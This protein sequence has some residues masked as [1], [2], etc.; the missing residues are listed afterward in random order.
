MTL[1]THLRATRQLLYRLAEGRGH[2]TPLAHRL[3]LHEAAA[4]ALCWVRQVPASRGGRGYTLA[5]DDSCPGMLLPHSVRSALDGTLL[6]VQAVRGLRYA[7]AHSTWVRAENNTHK[8]LNGTLGAVLRPDSQPGRRFALTAGHVCGAAPS[9]ASGDEVR[10]SFAAGGAPD[11]MGR[12]LDWQPNFT[13]LPLECTLDAGLAEVSAE[14]LQPLMAR[15]D[16]WPTGDSMAFPEDRLSLRSQG[17]V[18]TGGDAALLGAPLCLNGDTSRSYFLRDALVW[19]TR[20]PSKAGDSGAPVWNSSDELVG[21]HA[22]GQLNDDPLS[23]IA[24]PIT[25]ILRWAGASLVRRS[26]L[27]QPALLAT[28]P[29]APAARRNESDILARTLYGEAIGEGPDGMAAVAHVVLNRV[30]ANTWWGRDVISVCQKPLQFSCWNANT[31]SRDRLLR[32][33]A[34]SPGFRQAQDAAALVLSAQA[35]GSRERNDPTHGATHYYAWR[36]IGPPNWAIG[37]TP[38]ARIGGHVFFKGIG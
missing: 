10:F 37:R 2:D 15:P 35:D 9:A 28:P 30:A 23:A 21:I 32:L 5:F 22:G 31:S 26:E 3:G 33:S 4:R 16:E 17:D 25:R 34:A 8:F 19:H 13:R 12:L 14:A 1:A 11:I 36:L 18:N 20:S 27:G 29:E 24:V 7:A 38:C 6:R